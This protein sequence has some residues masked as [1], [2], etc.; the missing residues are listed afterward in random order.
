MYKL[1]NFG[2]DI[3]IIKF[4]KEICEILIS[5]YESRYN[6]GSDFGRKISLKFDES[7]YKK[8]VAEDAYK[9]RDAIDEA[10]LLLE[11]EGLIFISYYKAT[12]D[13]SE[14]RLNID[15]IASVYKL[16]GTTNI[17]NKY[18]NLFDNLQKNG[19]GVS[20][21]FYDAL[22]EKRESKGS[23]QKYLDKASEYYDAVKAIDAI[24]SNEHDIF[25]RVLSVRLF[26]D[27]KR[28]E[29]LKNYVLD[30]FT[31][32]G[33][34]EATWDEYLLLNGILKNPNYIYLKGCCILKINEQI[35]D[36]TKLKTVMAI[37]SDSI[38]D[39]TFLSVDGNV[40]ATIENLTSFHD[41]KGEELAIYLGGFS[42]HS[43]VELLKK[44]N[45][46]I[47]GL[48]FRHFGDMDFG[49]FS[50]LS[51]LR[52]ET[53]IAI[54]PLHMDIK[55]LQDRV[56]LSKKP[57]DIYLGKLRSLLSDERLQDCHEAL[58]FMIDNQVILEQETY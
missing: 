42:N 1:R 35:V 55:M 57:S 18:Q 48:T 40:I 4:E 41:Y 31:V 39:T 44:L 37:C 6:N 30:V 12:K 9:Y 36:L 13:I 28:L 20:K 46:D 38:K 21:A 54:M 3:V 27:S 50:I 53:G 19:T 14:V 34:S 49:G 16:L 33:E 2:E 8:Y 26:R 10:V 25:M 52:R 56:E 24:N 23:L 22:I 7:G 51:H 43:K 45:A 17:A 5:K 58:Q 32:M 47:K 11:K 15:N 29:N